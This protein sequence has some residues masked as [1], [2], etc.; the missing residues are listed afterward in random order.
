MRIPDWD[1]LARILIHVR[2]SITLSV[3]ID[4]VHIVPWRVEHSQSLAQ[5][6]HGHPTITCFEINNQLPYEALDALYSALA[7][8]PNLASVGFSYCGYYTRMEDE[9][10]LAHHESLTELLR[11]PSLRSV[12]FASFFFTRALCQATANALMEGTAVTKLK[13]V[14]CEFRA[15]EFSVGECAAIMASGLS[16]NTSVISI[17][18]V[19][20]LDE[21]LNCA[22]AMALPSN[23]TLRELSLEVDD[24]G[25]A[26]IDWSPIFSALGKNSGPKSLTL[27]GLDSMEESLCTAMQTG[28]TLN[29]TLESLKL[30][31]IHLRDIEFAFWCRAFSFPTQL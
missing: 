7:T 13:F 26:Y 11:L 10:A 21:A 30:H 6:I 5:A 15:F 2:Q 31:N 19:V 23:S 17:E 25:N 14:N 9:S 12:C 18:V 22:L 29:K 16:K 8:L 20:P 24:D 3:T 27:D 28:L 1:V 4:S